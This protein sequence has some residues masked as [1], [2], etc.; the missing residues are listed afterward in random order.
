MWSVLYLN[1]TVKCLSVLIHI[2]NL[3]SAVFSAST[4]KWCFITI[5][6]I[7][8]LMVNLCKYAVFVHPTFLRVRWMPSLST[9]HNLSRQPLMVLMITPRTLRATAPPQF[10]GLPPRGL[11]KSPPR[12]ILIRNLLLTG[13]LSHTP[14]KEMVSNISIS[15]AALD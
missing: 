14:A 7:Y 15:L 6:F 1:V 9:A 8:Y 4:C 10:P 12:G 3:Y 11:L 2:I 13:S 5:F